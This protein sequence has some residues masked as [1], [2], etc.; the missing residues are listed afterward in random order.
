[1]YIVPTPLHLY[2]GIGNRIITIYIDLYGT[3]AVYASLQTIKTIRDPGAIGRSNVHALN[4]NELSKWVEN[5][6]GESVYAASPNKANNAYLVLEDW[7]KQLKHFCLEKTKWT[8]LDYAQFYSLVHLIRREWSSTTE[9]TPFPKL[10][11]LLHA[12]QFAEFHG[13]LSKLS[14]SPM[15]S[16]HHSFNEKYLRNHLNSIRTKSKRIRRCLADA[17]CKALQPILQLI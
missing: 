13:M 11:M 8:N 9:D 6:C 7:L 1:M 4:G 10:H 15:E 17:V 12:A 3:E 2:L 5:K 14:E 16:Y